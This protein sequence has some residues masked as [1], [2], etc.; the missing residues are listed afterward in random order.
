V[1]V[2]VEKLGILRKAEFELGDLTIICGKNNTS[3]T[4]ATYALYGFLRSWDRILK[5]DIP[6]NQINELI[7]TGV[8]RIDLVDQAKRI[9]SVLKDGCRE[10]RK[11]L[12]RVF[13]SRDTYFKD[14][15]FELEIPMGKMLQNTKNAS[16]KWKIGFKKTEIFLTKEKG[17]KDIIF[18][19]LADSGRSEV[20]PV[21]T[22]QDIISKEIIEIL[23]G[24]VFPRPFIVSTERTGAT[25]FRKELDFAH[26]RLLEEMTRTDKK[27]DPIKLLFEFYQDYALP[28]RDNV[29]FICNLDSIA[30]EDGFLLKRYPDIL[31]QFADIIGGEYI[32]QSNNILHF[33]PK[34]KR[35]K[36]TMGES[37]S[38]VRSMLDIGFYLRHKA[39]P[40]D[41]LMV[42]EPELNLHPE[43]QRRV[44]RLL[45]R[46]VNLGIKV[47]I[48]THTDDVL[49]E[50][51]VGGEHLPGEVEV[52]ADE[53]LGLRGVL[54]LGHPAAPGAADGGE[55]GVEREHV[56]RLVGAA[57][58]AV[59]PPHTP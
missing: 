37:S 14:S 19:L 34:N 49:G 3:K 30:K 1:K 47:F 45:A 6:S 54:D 4:Y 8:T 38:A 35:V 26:N 44:A 27:I 33:K 17:K 56:G 12:P 58:A 9:D 22:I 28:V 5:I 29:D 11:V 13:A 36:L 7:D 20:P 55:V 41:L 2:R 39:K 24:S 52:V 10:Y 59:E 16:F 43:N 57:E 50:L 51:A 48:T 31:N 46:L 25:I 18:S 53:S 15:I 21:S 40:G 42:E 23:F 32:V